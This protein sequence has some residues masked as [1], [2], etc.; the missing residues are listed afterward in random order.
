MNV[1]KYNADINEMKLWTYQAGL[2]HKFFFS[3]KVNIQFP[4]LQRI[5]KFKC[6]P[7]RI[8]DQVAARTYKCNGITD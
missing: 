2:A 7:H 8:N 6:L 4:K 1:K 5:N 3:F